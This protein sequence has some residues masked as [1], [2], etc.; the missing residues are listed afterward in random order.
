L[1]LRLMVNGYG[2]TEAS[3]LVPAGALAA[4]ILW[5][6][7]M[8]AICLL[9]VDRVVARLGWDR[10]R[11]LIRSALH[12]LCGFGV[13][14]GRVP[15]LN[16]WHVVT[17]P[18]ALADGIV[19]VLHPLMVPLVVA[20][21]IAFALSAAALTAIGQAAVDRTR[22]IARAARRLIARGPAAA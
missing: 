4:L 19:S 15:R 13:V 10:W 18:G 17:R 21:A 1:H 5:G 14:L 11:L 8:Y 3:A 2:G 6:V 22:E 16:S 20:L 7:S 12:L 9:E